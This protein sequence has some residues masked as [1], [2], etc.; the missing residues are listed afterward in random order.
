M[1]KFFSI[2]IF[3][4]FFLNSLGAKEPFLA[5][6]VKIHSN[7]T[8]VF[9]YGNT[10]F[11]CKVHGVIAIDEIYENA[12]EASAC[13]KS[14]EL[15]Y[16][17]QRALYYYANSKLKVYQSYSLIV[18]KNNRCLINIAGEKTLSE[19]LIEEG[20]AVKKPQF[21][22]KEYSYYFNRSE[23]KAKLSLRGIWSEN[24]MKDCAAYI[25][26]RE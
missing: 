20:L 12:D 16:K 14:I 15:F 22:D 2:F 7:D 1:H 13:T 9:R 5:T 4:I 17:K 18:K 25:Y 10:E 6:L 3:L 11:I 8:Q 23:Q 26:T 21:N 24:M 19:F